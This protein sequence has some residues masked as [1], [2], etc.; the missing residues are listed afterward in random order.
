MTIHFHGVF[1]SGKNKELS[2]FGLYA[3]D[4]I[5]P[6]ALHCISNI[7]IIFFQSISVVK[8]TEELMK[9]KSVHGHL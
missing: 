1:I 6:Q 3:S 9:T 4:E 7:D 5:M 2:F 8:H